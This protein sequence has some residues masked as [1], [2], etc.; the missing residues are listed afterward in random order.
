MYSKEQHIGGLFTFL[1][2]LI[3][4]VHFVVPHHHH[5]ELS[6]LLEQKSTCENS[7]QE[8]NTDNN[9][10]HCYAFNVL[11]SKRITNSSVYQSLFEYSGYFLAGI[12]FSYKIPPSKNIIETI[13]RYSPL[14][15]KQYVY[16]TRS[17]RAP[18]EI[19]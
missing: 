13:F 12:I 7:A 9:D 11:V 8:E 19:A 14:I 16:S 4:L 15:T 18:P 1:A 6:H 5:F 2:S 17:L 3:I 10:S